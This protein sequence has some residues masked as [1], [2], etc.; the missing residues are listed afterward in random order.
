[1]DT[2]VTIGEAP[3]RL[4]HYPKNKLPVAKT[5]D[6]ESCFRST[7]RNQQEAG[8]Y[9]GDLRDYWRFDIGAVS[10]WS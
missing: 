2:K 3:Q 10:G 4:N 8:K 5:N 1:M 7:T 9:A 6:G